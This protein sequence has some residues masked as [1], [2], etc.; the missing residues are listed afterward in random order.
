M[1]PGV[2]RA[3][4]SSRHTHRTAARYATCC[5]MPRAGSRPT[6]HL[7]AVLH[8][9][10]ADAGIEEQHIAEID[11]GT[12]A[13]DDLEGIARQADAAGDA[14]T[15][16]EQG[17]AGVRNHA[18]GG[19]IA[20]VDIA[21]AA[22]AQ[23]VAV[24][25]AGELQHRAVVHERVLV[26]GQV[27]DAGNLDVE[28]HRTACDQ[29]RRLR[30]RQ[31]GGKRHRRGK[32]AQQC[33][34]AE[35]MLERAR[36][37]GDVADVDHIVLVDV[38]ACQVA[39]LAAA[40]SQRATGQ[41][42]VGAV[43]GAVGIDVACQRDGEVGVRDVEEHVADRLDLDARRAGRHCRQYHGLAAAVGRAGCQHGREGLAAVGGQRDLHIGRAN[44]RGAGVGH[45]P[46]HVQRGAAHGRHAGGRRRHQERTGAGRQHQLRGGVA[47]AAAAVTRGQLEVERRRAGPGQAH[48][49]SGGQ[50]LGVALDDAGSRGAGHGR[51]R[52]A[53]GIGVVGQDLRQVGEH[54]GRIGGHM[55]FAGRVVLDGVAGADHGAHAE[56]AEQ[57]TVGLD[58]ADQ[59]GAGAA[60]IVVLFPQVSDGIAVGI[61][62]AAGQGERRAQRNRVARGHRHHRHAVAGAGR[63]T[64]T[65]AGAARRDFTHVAADGGAAGCQAQ[66]RHIDTGQHAAERQRE[67]VVGQRADGHGAACR[68]ARDALDGGFHAGR[69]VVGA[70]HDRRRW[71]AVIRQPEAGAVGSKAGEHA[72]LDFVEQAF[73]RRRQR[74]DLVKAAL[75]PVGVAV[76]LQV[77][78]AANAGVRHDRRAAARLHRRAVVAVA[79]RAIAVDAVERVVAGELVTQLVRDIV[80]RVKVAHRGR[81]A[82]APLRLGG[83]AHHAQ[84]G[85]TAAVQAQRDM[86]HVVV[87]GAGQQA[88]HHAVTGERAAA[89]GGRLDRGEARRAAA[90]T[91]GARHRSVGIEVERIGVIDQ[92]QADR[93]FIL[94]HLGHPVDQR[95]L[96]GGDVF[97]TKVCR[98]RRV[99]HQRQPVSAQQV[100]GGG[101]GGR[102]VGHHLVRHGAGGAA[103]AGRHFVRPGL[104]RRLGH[105]RGLD[106]AVGVGVDH[107]ALARARIGLRIAHRDADRGAGCEA[108]AAH[109]QRIAGMVEAALERQLRLGDRRLAQRAAAVGQVARV[110]AV[111]DAVVAHGARI[112]K[113]A[114]LRR[115][116]GRVQA[117]RRDIHAQGG[118]RIVDAAAGEG[119]NLGVLGGQPLFHHGRIDNGEA[120]VAAVR[121]GQRHDQRAGLG[122]HRPLA[123]GGRHERPDAVAVERGRVVPLRAVGRGRAAL[124]AGGGSRGGVLPEVAARLHG[125]LFGCRPCHGPAQCRRQQRQSYCLLELCTFHCRHAP[126]RGALLRQNYYKSPPLKN[127]RSS[128][129]DVDARIHETTAPAERRPVRV[130]RGR[131]RR[132]RGR[133]RVR[134]DIEQVVRAQ[135]Q[136]GLLSQ[137]IAALGVDNGLGRDD[138]VGGGR[139]AGRDDLA[140]AG[141]A[142]AGAPFCALPVDGRRDLVLR[143]AFFQ[144]DHIAAAKQH[145]GRIERGQFG[146]LGHALD[147][148]LVVVA[149]QREVELA[150]A[151]RTQRIVGHDVDAVGAGIDAV[152]EEARTAHAGK[153]FRRQVGAHIG[154]G[155]VFRQ[156][157][158]VVDID[159]VSVGRDAQVAK[160]EH[161]AQRE[162][163]RFFRV[164]RLGAQRHGHRVGGTERGDIVRHAVNERGLGGG[165][166]LLLRRRRAEAVLHRAAQCERG[167]EIVAGRDLARVVAAEVG[168]MLGARSHRRQ[169]LVGEIGFQVDER[170]HR[171]AALVDGI[172]GPVADKALGAGPGR[173][174]AGQHGAAVA[175]RIGLAGPQF[176]I[177]VTHFRAHRHVQRFRQERQFH[178]AHGREITGQLFVGETARV[179]RGLAGCADRAVERVGDVERHLVLAVGERGVVIPALPA[180][181]GA[182]RGAQV[183]HG[184]F[185]HGQVAVRIQRHQVFILQR[186]AEERGRFRFAPL[187]AG[188]AVELL[189]AGQGLAGVGKHGGLFQFGIARP[190]VVAVG[191]QLARIERIAHARIELARVVRAALAVVLSFQFGSNGQEAVVA[192]R[193]TFPAAH[194]IGF[195]VGAAAVGGHGQ[196]QAGRWGYRVE[197]V[198]GLAHATGGSERA[199]AAV[200]A[201]AEVDHAGNRIGTILGGSAVAQH[202]HRV[203]DAGRQGVDVGRGRTAADGAVDIDQRRRMAALGV[204][205][206]QHLVGRQAAQRDGTHGV[207]AVG[208]ARARKVQRRQ[209][210]RQ[211][212][213]HFRHAVIAERLGRDHV[214]CRR[215]V[216][217]GAVRD[218]GAGDHHGRFR[219]GG[220]GGVC[221]GSLLLRNGAAGG[222]HGADGRGQQST[223]KMTL[224]RELFHVTDP[225][226]K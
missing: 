148:G 183:G 57:R 69:R 100:A 209:D 125:R 128:E 150:I 215:R 61:L 4:F 103:V 168:V 46:R 193:K 26:G 153:T 112:D 41:R 212:L 90:G 109:F 114:A 75:R 142:G 184:W 60:A 149:G 15:G 48:V 8:R 132:Q 102:I 11:G 165:V 71:H 152:D 28:R 83:G 43:D 99:G 70:A 157:D 94:V 98:V 124:G 111:V 42:Q 39:G 223:L 5:G 56:L 156:H 38:G 87:A 2:A 67:G 14:G 91:V 190:G 140:I 203:D 58:V 37:D 20:A 219:R 122:V 40:P 80:D 220:R 180:P 18:G 120:L 198:V 9:D 226:S 12:A 178:G 53:G 221:A 163:D 139:G 44:R 214:H 84:A 82:G 161:G 31:G 185:D 65:R 10:V 76:S 166:Q 213:A 25:V 224:N 72:H 110:V 134:V 145:G 137:R 170:A 66:H 116:H 179:E 118:G 217:H 210:F 55:V 85:N 63:R 104:A 3:P 169:Q 136:L 129:R 211:R 172:V 30:S 192:Q 17:A 50:E 177:F 119:A 189:A 201:Q 22:R 207:G 54:A 204:H 176:V 29:R 95:D 106:H 86:T 19:R 35:E 123:R 216:E 181:G 52:A 162:V 121:M 49:G 78:G 51:A 73:G 1:A 143:L 117:Q 174:A 96:G 115:A 36:D 218:A 196:A 34:H 79:A 222:T 146:R 175:V 24:G 164:Q 92:H 107:H 160:A 7:R 208:Q 74:D 89:A 195:A 108:G 27:G 97:R 13:A 187:V 158:T 81:Q 173:H 133:Q 147:V 64:A 126:S 225:C 154:R 186:T 127:R 32:R 155:H 45:V 199:A 93:G 131:V 151:R 88:R 197:A 23:E 188:P 182:E 141:G 16:A 77:V 135:R 206:H 59:A 191:G 62:G 68:P 101:S 105:Q 167:R 202:F 113:P 21:V 200:F 130:R 159:A 205:Q 138:G 171:V 6:R 33:C 144:A 194:G 47:H